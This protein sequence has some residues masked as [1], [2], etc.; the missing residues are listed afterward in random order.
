MI[1]NKV[2]RDSYYINEAC[3]KVAENVGET[4][5]LAYLGGS[6][7]SVPSSFV[8]N[9]LDAFVK[10]S[11]Y[12]FNPACIAY[13]IISAAGNEVVVV[14]DGGNTYKFND[15]DSIA[16]I[17][18]AVAGLTVAMNDGRTYLVNSSYISKIKLPYVA[19]TMYIQDTE[20]GKPR[21]IEVD[22]KT[23]EDNPSLVAYIV[24]KI[25]AELPPFTGREAAQINKFC[26][27]K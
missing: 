22:L 18:A 23:I 2:G 25:G 7:E 9:K 11:K 3:V 21:A 8:G 20:T 13:S 27:G 12:S 16:A 15:T 5:S 19:A 6:S 24:L 10:C 4:V 14:I 17:K 1:E 26:S